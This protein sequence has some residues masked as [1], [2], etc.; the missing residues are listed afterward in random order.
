MRD[1][2]AL[3]STERTCVDAGEL[4]AAVVLDLASLEEEDLA[5]VGMKKLEVQRMR[6][7]LKE[8]S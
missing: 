8:V 6:R 5:E 3:G 2:H 7:V 4:G 1:G